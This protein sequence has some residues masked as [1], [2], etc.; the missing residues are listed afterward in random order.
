[1][2]RLK[3][4]IAPSVEPITLVEARDHLHLDASG[5][6]LS[7]PDDTLISSLI[8]AVRNH[9]D[10]ADG[11]LGRAL[12]PQTWE[13]YLDEFSSDEIYIPL[14][15]LVSITSVKYDDINGAEQTVSSG[16]YV[17]DSVSEPGWV[18]P[19]ST[20]SWP[21]TM[22]TPNAVRIRYQAGYVSGNSPEDA[23]KV[24]EAIKAAMKLM[25]GRLY[26]FRED[27]ISGTIIAKLPDGIEALLNPYRIWRF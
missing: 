19:V 14:P 26:E 7:H 22:D 13:L 24:P 10:G 17:V 1:M 3:L 15:R 8:V 21:D 6:P 18:L 5:S 9:I 16:D 20:F 4:I 2:P 23:S 25:L 11:Y 27:T 12:I